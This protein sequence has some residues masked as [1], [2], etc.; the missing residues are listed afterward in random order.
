MI[1]L[2]FIIGELRVEYKG[3]IADF[4]YRL[5]WLPSGA[6]DCIKHFAILSLSLWSGAASKAIACFIESIFAVVNEVFLIAAL[7]HGLTGLIV[8]QIDPLGGCRL[9]AS[10]EGRE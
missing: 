7:P 3:I 2:I 10:D 5:C 4:K 1:L 8:A 6:T 9:K